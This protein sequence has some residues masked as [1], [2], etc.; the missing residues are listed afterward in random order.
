MTGTDSKRVGRRL[1]RRA[2]RLVVLGLVASLSTTAAIA[3]IVVSAKRSAAVTAQLSIRA[4]PSSHTVAPGA[5]AQYTVRVAR[6]NAGRRGLSGR[7]ELSVDRELPTGVGI[8][9][10][11]QRGLASSTVTGGSTTLTVT[12]AAG[13][14]PGAYTLQVRAR[15]PHRSGSTGI[16]LIVSGRENQGTDPAATVPTPL[17]T[18]DAFTISGAL[19]DLLTPGAGEPLDLELTNRESTDISI[20]SLSVDLASAA[21]PQASAA[22]PCRPADFLIGQFSGGLG[23]TLPASSSASLSELGFRPAEWPEVSML[24]LLVNQDGCKQASLDLSFSG[25]ANE[26]SP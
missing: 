12:T 22:H 14:P 4:E 10:A 11:P 18:P 15:R 13:T 23:F 24:N 25:T 8:S 19:S 21:G 16:S 2:T 7:T 6:L 20:S 26:V 17:V 3:A 1:H 9:F 5:A